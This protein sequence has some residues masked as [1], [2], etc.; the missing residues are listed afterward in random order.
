MMEGKGDLSA[1]SVLSVFSVLLAE[2]WCCADQRFAQL[3]R[4]QRPLEAAAP[5]LAIH[6]S[7]TSDSAC[8]RGCK[9]PAS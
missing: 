6:I 3:F 5:G 9:A 7:A 2:G 8:T 1:F 4:F